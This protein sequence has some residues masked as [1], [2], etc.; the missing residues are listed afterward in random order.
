MSV[1]AL[2]RE[3][4]RMVGNIGHGLKTLL[5]HRGRSVCQDARHPLNR[6]T[7]A[8]NATRSHQSWPEMGLGCR[9]IFGAEHL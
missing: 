3:D 9:K 7:A 1:A 4:S 5:P 8:L 2:P 6:G